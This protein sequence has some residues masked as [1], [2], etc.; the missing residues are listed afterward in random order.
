MYIKHTVTIY[1]PNITHTVNIEIALEL[2]KLKCLKFET[3]HNTNQS[4]YFGKFHFV[5]I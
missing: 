4:F 3:F 5:F 1:N 2:C